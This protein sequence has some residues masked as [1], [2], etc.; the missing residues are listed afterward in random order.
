VT[1]GS[2]DVFSESL[3]GAQATVVYVSDYERPIWE[4]HLQKGGRVESM[5]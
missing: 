2:M 4:T 5:K 3:G 1:H